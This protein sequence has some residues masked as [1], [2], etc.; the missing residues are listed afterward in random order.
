MLA[1][2]A[3]AAEI[4]GLSS[5]LVELDCHSLQTV[6][7]CSVGCYHTLKILPIENVH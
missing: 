3:A 5:D 7:C 1:V 4:N 6:C 2:P